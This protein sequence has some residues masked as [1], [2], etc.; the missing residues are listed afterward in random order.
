MSKTHQ[1]HS[2]KGLPP[3]K[4]EKEHEIQTN[5]YVPL[6]PAVIARKGKDVKVIVQ[7]PVTKLG[8]VAGFRVENAKPGWLYDAHTGFCLGPAS[9]E[10]KAQHTRGKIWERQV[11]GLKQKVVIG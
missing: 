11:A 4:C 7:N 2:E 10:L 1:C 5:D 6:G 3:C 8:F 9:D